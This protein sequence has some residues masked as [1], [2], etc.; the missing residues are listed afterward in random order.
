MQWCQWRYSFLILGDPSP[1]V[2]CGKDGCGSEVILWWPRPLQHQMTQASPWKELS[3]SCQKVTT[4]RSAQWI[5]SIELK[6]SLQELAYPVHH[7]M[8]HTKSTNLWKPFSYTVYKIKFCCAEI[9][10]RCTVGW[11]HLH[12]VFLLQV[13]V[14]VSS[15]KFW[16]SGSAKKTR[17]ATPASS[18]LDR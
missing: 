17:K 9:R 16:L 6:L 13:E 1:R 15:W 5:A 10:C 8:S 18:T 3:G 12:H 2:W 11:C 4:T 14:G 7:L